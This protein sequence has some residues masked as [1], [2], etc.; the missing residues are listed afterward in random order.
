MNFLIHCSE[1]RE[2][3]FEET[4]FLGD[5]N[6]RY[7]VRIMRNDDFEDVRESRFLVFTFVYTVF[8]RFVNFSYCESL[9]N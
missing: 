8:G 6:I 7:C 4:L 3:V 5:T 1:K 2:K 9:K